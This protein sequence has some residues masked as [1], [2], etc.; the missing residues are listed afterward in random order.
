ME[1]NRRVLHDS[2][3]AAGERRD[4]QLRIRELI[5]SISAGAGGLLHGDLAGADAA[6]PGSSR[7][8]DR[9]RRP[10]TGR[11][12]RNGPLAIALDQAPLCSVKSPCSIAEPEQ[13]AVYVEIETTRYPQGEIRGQLRGCSTTPNFHH[14]GSCSPPGYPVG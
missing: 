14:R 12:P 4:Q 11:C 7:S 1:F 8:A 3:L 9:A 13:F 5:V 10:P 6:E 2:S